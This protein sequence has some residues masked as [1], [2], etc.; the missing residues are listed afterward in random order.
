MTGVTIAQI[1]DDTAVV[2]ASSGD[3]VTVVQGVEAAGPPG[4]GGGVTDHGALTGLGDDDHTQYVLVAGD[5]MTGQLA[6]T[7]T[8]ASDVAAIIR[9]VADSQGR[10]RFTAG[11]NLQFDPSGAA[12]TAPM[13]LAPYNSGGYGL[14]Q[15][16]FDDAGLTSYGGI[17]ALAANG[18]K[19]TFILTAGRG[20]VS[21]LTAV[22]AGDVLGE[23]AL[24]GTA[25]S[26]AV[27][28]GAAMIARAAENWTTGG[29]GA[30]G[31]ILTLENVPRSSGLSRAASVVVYDNG[32]VVLDPAGAGVDVQ[33]GT[34]TIPDGRLRVVSQ[35]TTETTA[36]LKAASSQTAKALEVQ[37]SS[38][39]V[40]AS[41]SAGGVG[42]F[43]ASTTV[44]G[45]VVLTAATI[46]TDG[47]LAANSDSNVASQKATKTY[48]DTAVAAVGFDLA[49]SI[50]FGG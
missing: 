6:L 34:L 46:D 1:G 36:V 2:V 16:C 19:P 38:G 10:I 5:T 4:S 44:G 41:I 25:S 29:G 20:P 18:A 45:N 3:N 49:Q 43:A 32:R 42:A 39:T 15:F 23:I 47:T 28:T 27:W 17:Q 14:L 30:Y 12:T 37:N 11:G 13:Y 50:A 26:S 7:R 8:N 40:Q 31:G 33:F 21:A 9:K 24:Q 48:V 22:Q 35:A